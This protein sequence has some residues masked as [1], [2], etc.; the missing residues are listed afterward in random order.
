MYA[1]EPRGCSFQRGALLLSCHDVDVRKRVYKKENNEK[2]RE[3][4]LIPLYMLPEQWS[5][6]QLIRRE[7]DTVGL[8]E[9]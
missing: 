7:S 3:V 5:I 4:Y 6:A 8:E 2:E 9:G 1:S